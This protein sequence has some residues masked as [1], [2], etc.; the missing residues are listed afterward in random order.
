[1]QPL[2]S[3][4]LEVLALG[5][6][7]TSLCGRHCGREGRRR[8][9]RR[10]VSALVGP[11]RGHEYNTTLVRHR[12]ETSAN[13]DV[14]KGIHEAERCHVWRA[15]EAREPNLSA[16]TRQAPKLCATGRARGRWCDRSIRPW[17]SHEPSDGQRARS[18]RDRRRGGT[19]PL[20]GDTADEVQVQRTPELAW[21]LS[22]LPARAM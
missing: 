19:Q 7:I 2:E 18:R 12:F 17:W 9:A 1:M 13:C 6:V 5:L 4:V 3:Y 14:T 15:A 20:T 11:F 8:E 21:S 16:E 22:R 10:S